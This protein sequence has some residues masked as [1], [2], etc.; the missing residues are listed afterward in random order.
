LI[1]E[2]NRACPCEPASA[3]VEMDQDD[4]RLSIH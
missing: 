2:G 4:I 3:S 1:G